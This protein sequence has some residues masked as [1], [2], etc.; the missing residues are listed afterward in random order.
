MKYQTE[1]SFLHAE[2][3]LASSTGFVLWAS[4]SN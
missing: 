1:N 3:I 2:V 4:I